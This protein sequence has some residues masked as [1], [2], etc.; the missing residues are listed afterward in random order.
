VPGECEDVLPFVLVLPAKSYA[1]D[2][3]GMCFAWRSP[4]GLDGN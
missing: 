4:A 2:P 1:P 3:T